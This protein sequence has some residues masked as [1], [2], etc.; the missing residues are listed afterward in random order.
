MVSLDSGR[1]ALRYHN[2]G[3][4]PSA[5][6][7]VDKAKQALGLAAGVGGYVGILVGAVFWVPAVP[8][9]LGV[10][11]GALGYV[12]WKNRVVPIADVPLMPVHTAVGAV[13]KRGTAR[14][15]AETAKSVVDGSQVLVEQVT[16]IRG[17]V[18]LRRTTAVPFLLELEGDRIVVAGAL[19]VTSKAKSEKLKRS[20]PIAAALGIP[21]QLPVAGTLEVATVR[22]G[23]TIR[24]TG[25]PAVEMVRE[26]AFHRDAG[27]VNVMRGAPGAVVAIAYDDKAA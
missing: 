22:D 18:L 15:L 3:V 27:E 10:G 23:D 9:I 16:I 12:G 25:V 2:L 21:P 7:R 1:E 14:K 13:E 26:L 6:S 5:T 17:G 11:A 24:V 4:S 19:R 20:D 8:I